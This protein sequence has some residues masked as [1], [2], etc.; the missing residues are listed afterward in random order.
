MAQSVPLPCSSAGRSCAGPVYGSA[1]SGPVAQLIGL[2]Y[3]FGD[4]LTGSVV[5]I[6]ASRAFGPERARLLLLLGGLQ[7]IAV[8]DSTFAYLTGSGIYTARGSVLDAAWVAGF[9]LI[10]LAALW[11][12]VDSS[13][14][15]EGPIQSWPGGS[16]RDGIRSGDGQSLRVLAATR[17]PWGPI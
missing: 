1:T 3:P 17:S 8:A 9:L 2:A 14:A 11:P 15:E 13:L 7:A 4:I 6:I 5:I 12:T 10:A 16:A